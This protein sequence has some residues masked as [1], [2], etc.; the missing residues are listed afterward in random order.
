M[1]R[2]LEGEIVILPVEKNIIDVFTGNGWESWS[3]FLNTGTYL[4]LIKGS[5]VSDSV[6]AQ[7]MKML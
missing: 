6:Y 1:K 2:K 7:L 4:K 3:R 5:G